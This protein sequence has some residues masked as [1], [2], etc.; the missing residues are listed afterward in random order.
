MAGRHTIHL[1]TPQLWLAMPQPCKSAQ[2]HVLIITLKAVFSYNKTVVEISCNPLRSTVIKMEKRMID[3][4]AI[5]SASKHFEKFYYSEVF[6]DIIN[7]FSTGMLLY[8]IIFQIWI[9]MKN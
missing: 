9:I 1:T 6:T 2:H 8:N 5:A 7:H 4:K 3:S